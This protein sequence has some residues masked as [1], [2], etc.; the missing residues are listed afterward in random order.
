[1]GVDNWKYAFVLMRMALKNRRK[2]LDEREELAHQ[3]A[4]E[5]KQADLQTAMQLGQAQVA[6]KDQNIVTQG[7]IDEMVN[8]SLNAVK[9]Q[10]QAA[11]KQQTDELRRGENKEKSDQQKDQEANKYNLEQQKAIEV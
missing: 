11:L 5:L 7:K 9:F 3:R 8:S 4:M 2:E 1:M 6:G 10:A